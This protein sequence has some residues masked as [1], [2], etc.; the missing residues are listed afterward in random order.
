MSLVCMHGHGCHWRSCRARRACVMHAC[1]GSQGGRGQSP[2]V[3]QD[4]AAALASFPVDLGSDLMSTRS[5]FE[6]SLTPVV[7][8]YAS[9][10]WG[11][12]QAPRLT[13]GAGYVSAPLC[14][15]DC[16]LGYQCDS[17]DD[18]LLDLLFVDTQLHETGYLACL[19]PS[20]HLIGSLSWSS[21]KPPSPITTTATMGHDGD[22]GG[23]CVRLLT[24]RAGM[25][26]RT[27]TRTTAAATARRRTSTT[28]TAAAGWAGREP[29]LPQ[30][31]CQKPPRCP[32]APKNGPPLP[33]PISS[34]LRPHKQSRSPAMEVS[35]QVCAVT[36]SCEYGAHACSQQHSSWRPWCTCSSFPRQSGLPLLA[37]HGTKACSCSERS[38]LGH[39]QGPYKRCSPRMHHHT[40]LDRPGAAEAAHPGQQPCSA[41]CWWLQ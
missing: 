33:T 2:E 31:G 24:K 15:Q 36:S 4:P 37:Q 40:K 32:P 30:R 17:E 1:C 29:P 38:C 35:M 10:H 19:L 6:S 26:P 13:D 34:I 16:K 39:A 8:P 22:D 3:S 7:R 11:C 27:P 23:E 14:C 41:C 20:S 9:S 12:I 25:P 28:S 21:S 5:S 18:M